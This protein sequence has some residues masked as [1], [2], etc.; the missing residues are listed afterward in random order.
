MKNYCNIKIAKTDHNVITNNI[1]YTINGNKI[2]F[3]EWWKSHF[4][5]FAKQRN[6]QHNSAAY[7]Q[8]NTHTS[9]LKR[10]FYNDTCCQD[11]VLF[12]P[13]W[14]SLWLISD[15][16]WLYARSKCVNND[17]NLKKI[18]YL[19]LV[20]NKLMEDENKIFLNERKKIFHNLILLLC[21]EDL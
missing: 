20:F 11:Q 16:L 15:F 3:L 18:T 14:D 21:V 13:L 17:K 8:L 2:I 5:C 19:W 9:D 1:L 4:I 10:H 12:E 6:A 7:L